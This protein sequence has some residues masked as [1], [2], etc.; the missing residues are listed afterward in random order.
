MTLLALKLLP[1]KGSDAGLGSEVRSDPGGWV[2]ARSPSPLRSH[3]VPTAGW[4]FY[5][6]QLES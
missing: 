6:Q 2:D 1:S 4:M 3:T 5:R